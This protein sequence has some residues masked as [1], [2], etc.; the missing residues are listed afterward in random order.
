MLRRLGAPL[1]ETEDDQEERG[2][3]HLCGNENVRLWTDLD[4]GLRVVDDRGERPSKIPNV[5][6][7][8]AAR[9][10]EVGR[11]V[12]WEQVDEQAG[13]DE[14]DDQSPENGRTHVIPA[15]HRFKS[16]HRK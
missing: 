7:G 4:A 12:V 3:Q 14:G 15:F 9:V 16:M 2:E 13:D 6:L 1:L 5:A 8:I 11:A 10:A